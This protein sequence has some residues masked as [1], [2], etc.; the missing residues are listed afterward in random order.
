MSLLPFFVHLV[1][2]VDTLD[3]A[4]TMTVNINE[5]LPSQKIEIIIVFKMACVK[6]KFLAIM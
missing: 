1:G 4:F 6:C 3:S 2:S 5:S